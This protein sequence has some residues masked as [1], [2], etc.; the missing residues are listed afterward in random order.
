LVGCAGL[1]GLLLAIDALALFLFL[2]LAAVVGG[3]PPNP[4]AGIVAYVL[5]PVLV[6]IGLGAAW[7]AY[8]YWTARA[9]HSSEAPAA[10]VR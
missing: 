9:T 7:G 5:L 4:Y 2:L 3:G 1:L 8:A 10:V 6:L